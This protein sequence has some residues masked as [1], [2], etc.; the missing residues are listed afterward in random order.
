MKRTLLFLIIGSF[1]IQASIKTAIFIDWK[2]HQIRITELYCVNKD[3]P[4]MHCNGQCYL[5]K[6]LKQIEQDYEESKAPFNP[7]HVKS[8]EFLLF[9]EHLS[10]NAVH[11]NSSVIPA[12]KGG[13][14]R[15]H[16]EQS[17]TSNFFHPPNY[18]SGDF[19]S[20]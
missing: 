17:F 13:I 18:F 9:F 14:Y 11:G 20:A 12:K 8:T 3:N 2:I 15:I 7:K 5:S 19:V 6:Q 1:L 16:Y 4:M 10:L